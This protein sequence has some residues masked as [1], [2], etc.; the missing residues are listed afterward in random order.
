M[1]TETQIDI[2]QIVERLSAECFEAHRG[3]FWWDE[4]LRIAVVFGNDAFS[5]DPAT[6][7]EVAAVRRVL[8]DHGGKE[9]V[10]ATNSEDAYTWA[11]ACE[12]PDALAPEVLQDL[13]WHAWQLAKRHAK[14]T[15]EGFNP[16]P[17][18]LDW[19][20]INTCIRAGQRIDPCPDAFM[21]LQTKIAYAALAQFA[22][23]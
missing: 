16:A 3:A 15:R 14:L 10:F 20:H 2:R 22:R 13:M 21:Y 19:N 17:L 4:A 6:E 8:T 9:L 18:A 1:V 12:L 11:I 23:A 5:S 7:F